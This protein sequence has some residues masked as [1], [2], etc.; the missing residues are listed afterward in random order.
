MVIMKIIISLLEQ[1][2]NNLCIAGN[3][4]YYSK[5]VYTVPARGWLEF[6]AKSAL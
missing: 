5:S 3:K 2:D 4:Y 1:M 6:M